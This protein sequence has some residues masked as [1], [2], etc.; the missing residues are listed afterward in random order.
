MLFILFL[1]DIVTKIKKR[2][3]YSYPINSCLP[4][5]LLY[6]S[7]KSPE[8]QKAYK[9][10]LTFYISHLESKGVS[11]LGDGLRKGQTM[12]DIIS[13]YIDNIDRTVGGKKVGLSPASKST[14]L[15]S[16][17]SFYMW[18]VDIKKV[19]VSNPA[20]IILRV[21]KFKK[22]SIGPNIQECEL[23]AIFDLFTIPP[24]RSGVPFFELMR[25]RDYCIVHVAASCGLRRIE[26][27]RMDVRSYD[28]DRQ[29]ITVRGK[30]GKIRTVPVPD[31]AASVLCHYLDEI[32]PASPSPIKGDE[33]AMFFRPIHNADKNI[34]QS[35]RMPPDNITDR[36]GG[37]LEKAGITKGRGPHT[38]RRS[39][40]AWLLNDS[41]GDL[42]LVQEVLGH[43][44]IGT[45]ERYT[46]LSNK[47][48]EDKVREKF[49]ERGLGP[50]QQ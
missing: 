30:G 15:S 2:I 32:R 41:G 26:I 27:S 8:T 37:L 10:I 47:H 49:R 23:Q 1:R 16:I 22:P 29:V 5:F 48:V 35:I 24:R 42:R 28:R 11:V 6:I 7:D 39:Y 46:A 4:S 20:A 12:E 40:G 3:G 31:I 45:T 9:R 19:D 17:S 21:K 34:D 33:F 18:L 25:Q 44:N 36:I 38:L 43:A 50:E 14:Y 13:N